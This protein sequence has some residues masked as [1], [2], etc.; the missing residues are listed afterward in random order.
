LISFIQLCVL[1][2]LACEKHLGFSWT[3]VNK[4]GNQKQ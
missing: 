2:S 3:A 4:N 1:D